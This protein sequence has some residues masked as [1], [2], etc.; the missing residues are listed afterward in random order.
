MNMDEHGQM[1]PATGIYGNT[2]AAKDGQSSM[3]GEISG[4]S[5][6]VLELTWHSHAQARQPCASA[7]AMRYAPFEARRSVSL[8]S[9]GCADSFGEGSVCLRDADL[10]KSRLLRNRLIRETKRE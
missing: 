7:P 10:Q 1:Q 9:D 6:L 4:T 8:C 3:P 2:L 5:P